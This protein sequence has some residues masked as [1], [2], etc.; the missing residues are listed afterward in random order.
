MKRSGSSPRGWLRL[1]LMAF[2]LAGGATV[3]GPAM[4]D[5][6]KLDFKGSLG[7]AGGHKR[8]VPPLVNPLF[9]ETPYITTEARPLHLHYSLPSDFLT[10]GGT[11]DVTALE[12]RVAL[13]DRLGFIASK[14]GYVKANFDAVLPDDTG[15]ANI[16]FGFKY[17]VISNPKEQSILTVGAEYEPPTGSVATAGIDLQQGG[18]GFLDLFVTGAKAWDKFGLQGSFGYNHAIDGDHDTSSVH[19]SL[20]ADYELAPGFFPI[21]ELNGVTTVSDGT[22]VNGNF[23]GFDL[24]NFGTTHSGTVVTWAAGA[25]YRV[26]EHLQFG[27]GYE[28]PLTGREDII[29]WKL[30]VDAV[31]TY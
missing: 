3:S 1:S 19:Y 7:E 24:V 25:R 9:N 14:D 30:A 28:R 2:A 21:F 29:D 23:A 17:A 12:L 11:V 4:A 15:F 22:R 10:Q 26:N 16:S 31:I 27:L 18:D 20:H 5:D 8:Y 13:T 6:F